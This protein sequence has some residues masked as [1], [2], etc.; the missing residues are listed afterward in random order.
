M[1]TS[2]I[3]SVCFGGPNLDELYVTSAKKFLDEE[4]K[5]KEPLAGYIFR[6]TCSG[7]GFKGHKANFDLKL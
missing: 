2:L 3:T 6:I 7:S 1:P 4:R 5:A